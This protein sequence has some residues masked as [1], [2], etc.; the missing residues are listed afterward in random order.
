MVN[1]DKKGYNDKKKYPTKQVSVKSGIKCKAEKDES[2]AN[3]PLATE[4]SDVVGEIGDYDITRQE[5][6]QRLVS[7]FQPNPYKLYTEQTKPMDANS[8][9]LLMLGEKA[10]EM[11]ARKQGMLEDEDVKR[12]VD[13]YRQNQ[14]VN[15]WVRNNVLK[16]Q[17]RISAT[18]DEID[19]QL[20]TNSNLDHAKAKAL[21]E[22]TK[23]N[24]ILDQLYADL[25]KSS[26]VKKM[27]ENFAKVIE[28][29]DRLLNHPKQPQTMKFIRNTQISEELSDQERNMVLA[30]FS[31]GKITLKDWLETLCNYAPPSRPNNL[32][33][34]EGVSQ[35][36]DRAMMKPLIIA[37]VKTAGLDKDPAFLKQIRQMEDQ[38][39]L[40]NERNKKYSEVKE[41]PKEEIEAF[42]NENKEL[43]RAGRTLRIDQIWC[44]SLDA[45]KDVKNQIDTG[46]SFEEAKKEYAINPDVQASLVNQSSEGFFW[47]DLWKGEPNQIL[48]PIRGFNPN[49][50]N[51]RIVK[52]LA[53]NQ[54]KLQDFSPDL[55]NNIKYLIMTEQ[56]DKGFADYCMER[57]K[58]YPYEIYKDKVK[59]ID[60]TNVR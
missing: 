46:G 32:N 14:I 44:K 11:D 58:K 29:H 51:W 28:I 41:P 19:N 40:N 4:Q 1:E 56:A 12:A 26:D 50:L 52:I 59:D 3:E 31:G 9:L 57:L 2:T 33:T 15:L 16:S 47:F 18:E 54:G 34:K 53:K 35:L 48:G 13:T 10:L 49:G 60:P 43:F 5:L 20:K 23:A 22:N 42:Y 6:E 27:T 36:L 39:L 45:A 55:E 17:D 30:T 7:Q 37:Q 25:Y 24:K 21:V 38:T 8:M